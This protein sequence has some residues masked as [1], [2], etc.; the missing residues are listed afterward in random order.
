MNPRVKKIV[1]FLLAAALLFGA[2]RTQQSL[3]R[4]R[5]ALGLPRAAVLEN[6]PPMLAFTTVAL[7]GFRGLISNFLWIRANDLQQDDKFFEAAQLA[8]WITKLEP[9]YAQVW[10]FQAWNMAFNI[11]VKFKDN[12]PGDYSDRWRWVENGVRLLRDEGLRYNPNNVDIFRELAGLFQ[13]KIGGNLDDG[14]IYYKEQW[15]GEMKNFFGPNGT[16]FDQLLNPPDEAARTNAVLLREKYKLDAQFAKAVNEQYG[17]LDWRLPE[18]HAIYWA[19]L[20][21]AEAEKHPDKFK[22]DDLIKLRRTI[23]QSM[24]QAF[25]HGRIEANPFTH[26]YSLVPNL[27]LVAKANDSYEK[28]YVDET[29][30]AQKN[31]ILK[32]HRNFLRSAIYFLY[33]NNRV[34]E[35]AKW[36]KYLGEKYPDMPIVDN[37]P[38]SLPKNLSLDEY[39]VAVVQIDIG[40]TSQER[41]TSAMQG[42]LFHAYSNLALG[43]DDSYKNLEQLAKRVY[44]SYSDKT[45]A[46]GGRDRIPLPPFNDLTHAVVDQLLDPHEGLPFAARAELRTRLAK[47]V[48]TAA[49]APNPGSTNAVENVSTNSTPQ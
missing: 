49:P 48:E 38:T 10:I 13:F 8:D 7:G 44:E 41:V 22:I 46:N 29:D 32:A 31:G 11:S 3:N 12:A 37:D 5:D 24:Q 25:F 43:E 35:A 2:G 18:P 30:P 34:A 17:P 26:T 33:E 19:A 20:G 15:A 47:P 16:N 28:S 40:E 9:T 27:E 14:N 4:D 39:A 45:S 42:L 36:F 6:A 1:L 23:Y 21:L